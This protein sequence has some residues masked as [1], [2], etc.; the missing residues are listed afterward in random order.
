MKRA[1]YAAFAK[2]LGLTPQQGRHLI[3]LSYEAH[4]VQVDWHN[5]RATESQAQ[6]AVNAVAAYVKRFNVE[7]LDVGLWPVFR[8]DG[9]DIY[10]PD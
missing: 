8:K 6:K 4:N 5:G 7:M 10:L 2:R 1:V 9:Q 3:S